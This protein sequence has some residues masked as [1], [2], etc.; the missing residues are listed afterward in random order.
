MFSGE[1][2][3][4]FKN[5]YFEKHLR[6]AASVLHV[7]L[8]F[9]IFLV[10]WVSWVSTILLVRYFLFLMLLIW[11]YLSDIIIFYFVTFS[12]T[13]ILNIPCR[14]TCTNKTFEAELFSHTPSSFLIM[15][16]T[17][18]FLIFSSGDGSTMLKSNRNKYY[19]IECISIIVL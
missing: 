18:A 17:G 7:S 16:Q 5:T 19:F 11:K 6:R 2:C 4:I 8:I 1:N 15:R 9:S 3:E 14:F 10:L 13:N 12:L